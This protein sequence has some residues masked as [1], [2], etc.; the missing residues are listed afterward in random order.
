ME[1]DPME[2][3]PER[4]SIRSGN[5]ALAGHLYLPERASG[6]MPGVVIG[7][8]LTSRKERHAD[9]A[10]LLVANGFAALTFDL[11]GHGE[12]EGAL[13]DG[14]VADPI[15]AAEYLAGREEVNPARIALRGSS[16]GGML[17]IH[18][19]S[20]SERL[21]AVVALCPAHES[22]LRG[23]RGDPRYE[24]DIEQLAG[25]IRLDVEGFARYLR[26]HDVLSSAGRLAPRPLLLVHC[27]GDEVVPFSLSERLY[28]AAGEPKELWAVEGGSHTSAQHDPDLQLQVIAWIREQLAP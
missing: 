8:G 22:Q 19:A 13:D 4:V 10:R 5:I 17:G 25:E 11:R 9:F 18:A 24:A 1:G 6:R 16:L 20:G 28:Q 2:V 3:V 23:R 12:S 14:A 7:H 26:E 21:R 15:A 27:R